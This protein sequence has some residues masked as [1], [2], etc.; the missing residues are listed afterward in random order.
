VMPSPRAPNALTSTP[1][2]SFL[3]ATADGDAATA[4]ATGGQPAI[5]QL[6][7]ATPRGRLADS[8]STQA[9]A[10]ASTT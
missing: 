1:A 9:P 8:T 7:H 4:A 10:R 6:S 2:E 3:T 5:W